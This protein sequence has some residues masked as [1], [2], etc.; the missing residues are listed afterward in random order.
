MNAR[1]AAAAL[2]IAVVS[3]A[4]IGFVQP[5][6]AKDV[7]KVRLTDDGYYLPPPEQVRAMTLGHRAAAAD[8]LWAK[9]IL[10]YGL[11]WQEKRPF[12]DATRYVDAILAV[13]P[14]FPTLYRFIDTILVYTP[15]GG[16]ADDAR[17]ARRYLERGTRERPYDHEVWLQY[18]QFIAFLAPSFLTDKDEIEQWRVE[19]ATAIARAVELGSDANRSLAATTILGKSGERKATIEHLQRMYAITED[20][21]LRMQYRLR[22]QQLQASADAEAAMSV[23]EREWRTRYPFLTRGQAL[24]LGPRRSA[25]ACAGAASYERRGCASDWAR[26]IEEQK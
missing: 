9:L 15:G 2:A 19:G 23:V 18:G 7:H 26:A 17:A 24:L 22:L 25:T 4:G 21:E 8:L 5:K 3:V 16:T 20:P 6:L 10:E 11:H 14:D 12:P 13:E 1:A